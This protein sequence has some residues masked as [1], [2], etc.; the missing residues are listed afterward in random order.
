MTNNG[1]APNRPR[2]VV[3]NAED[4][5]RFLAI[6]QVPVHCNILWRDRRAA[7]NAPRGDIRLALCRR[8]GHVFNLAFD[9]DAVAYSE[10]YEN[11]L[12]FSPRFQ[13]YMM[14]LARHLVARYDLH[15][16]RIL[17]IGSGK[18]DFLRLLAQ[19]GDNR[20]IGFDPSYDPDKGDDGDSERLQFIQDYYSERYSSY[21]AD[22]IC[23][24]QVLE[25]LAAPTAFLAT[26]RR[27]IGTRCGTALFLEVPNALFMFRDLSVWDIIY[28][29]VSYFGA[30][31]LC[32]GLELGGF[33]VR[34]VCEAFEGQFLWADVLSSPQ[35]TPGSVIAHDL[36]PVA[37]YVSAFAT[38]YLERVAR[39]REDLDQLC[40]IG[41]R[42]VVWGAGSK[43]VMFLNALNAQDGIAYVVDINPRKRGMY[44]AGTGQMILPPRALVS[45]RP[46][47][48]IVMNPAY[49][50]EIRQTLRELG[51]SST[52]MPA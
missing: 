6:D 29:H 28:E 26:I 12:H 37:P 23:C 1:T 39:W 17:E 46:D 36:E 22:L 38:R 43:G 21:D 7:L 42:V 49:E 2:C 34:A 13:R 20:G 24:R 14:R 18:G 4:T 48:V 44:V 27:A 3:C 52:L 5:V 16:K 51:L 40:E 15:H 33:D 47:V 9:P 25:H 41:M 31:S 30:T 50:T 45:Y 10:A 8:C 11:S 35:G 32:R 19:L